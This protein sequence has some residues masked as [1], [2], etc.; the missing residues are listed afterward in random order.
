[1]TEYN[2]EIKFC[3]RLPPPNSSSRLKYGPRDFNFYSNKHRRLCNRS[4]SD[5][6][7]T[8]TAQVPV[9]NKILSSQVQDISILSSSKL[10]NSMGALFTF[11]GFCSV[12][13][14]YIGY[15]YCN[16]SI[17]ELNVLTLSERLSSTFAYLAIYHTRLA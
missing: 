4:N 10:S 6:E 9:S 12:D 8:I 7:E 1:M 14:R 3:L 5:Q 17:Y 11:Q 15:T 16:S 13:Y 2:K